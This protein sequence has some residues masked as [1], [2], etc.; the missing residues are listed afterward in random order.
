M[1]VS[2]L[3]PLGWCGDPTQGFALGC[4]GVGPSALGAVAG[5]NLGCYG[6]GLR[7]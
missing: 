2:G 1:Y 7:P 3:Q 6:A 5:S 4:Y